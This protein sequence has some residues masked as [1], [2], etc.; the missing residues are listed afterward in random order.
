MYENGTLLLVVKSEAYEV[1]CET[2]HGSG[3]VLATPLMGP[4]KSVLDKCPACHGTGTRSVRLEGLVEAS[5]HCQMWGGLLS[6]NCGYAVNVSGEWWTGK[7]NTQDEAWDILMSRIIAHHKSG[8]LPAELYAFDDNPDGLR[9]V[10][11]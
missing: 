8:T 5:T 2:C 7:V 10:P 4:S 3:T 9:E 11:A 1:E 6:W